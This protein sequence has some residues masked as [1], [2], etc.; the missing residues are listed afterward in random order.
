MRK[1]ANIMLH[2]F[3]VILLVGIV[4]RA[5]ICQNSGIKPMSLRSTD[6]ED[7]KSYYRSMSSVCSLRSIRTL[8]SIDWEMFRGRRERSLQRIYLEI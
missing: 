1:F 7:V 5:L 8:T 4:Y 2:S 3:F 6:G